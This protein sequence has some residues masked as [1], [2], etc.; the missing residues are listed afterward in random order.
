[1]IRI[2]IIGGIGAGKSFISKLFKYPVFNADDEVNYL[3]KNN[4]ECFK[5][6]KK[7]LPKFIKSFPIKKHE[8]IVAI[9]KDKKNLK[10]ISSIIHPL[11]RKK[12]A[13][14]IRQ[15]INRK[16]IILDVPLLIENKLY[17]KNDILIFVR[18]NKKTILNRLKN[19]PNYSKKMLKKLRDNQIILSK[20]KKLAN[21][22]LDNNFSKHIMKKKIKLLKNK[23]FHERNST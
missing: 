16:M 17:K 6:L 9:N 5:K 8:L 21:Y 3:Y 23:I 11:V 1:M 12:M 2:G 10:K 19:R 13:V 14:F 18:S 15:N 20:K 22:I 4:K 7:K